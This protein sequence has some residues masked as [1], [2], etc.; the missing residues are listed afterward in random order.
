MKA[1]NADG[2]S[3]DE[4]K[5]THNGPLPEHYEQARDERVLAEVNYGEFRGQC[6]CKTLYFE[7]VCMYSII[8]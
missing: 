3:T 8:F 4:G 1:G 5:D 7:P 6:A 2:A